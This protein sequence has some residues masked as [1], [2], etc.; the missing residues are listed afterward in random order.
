M[1]EDI[2]EEGKI[3]AIIGY[4]TIIGFIVGYFMNNDKKNPFASFHLRQSIGLWL[5]F[6]AVGIVVSTLDFWIVRLSFYIFFGVLFLF[7]LMTAVTGRADAAPL[8]GKIYQNLFS[9]LGK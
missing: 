2:I 3:P 9:G 8:V 7:S 6:F 1:T 4:L 5:S